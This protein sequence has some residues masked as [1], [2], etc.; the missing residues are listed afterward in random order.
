MAI[1]DFP[2]GFESWQKTHFEVVEALCYLRDLEEDKQP[3]KF[4]EFLDRTATDE[5][6]NLALKLTNKYE[7]QT[8]DK[9]RERNLFDEIEEFVAHEVK[10]L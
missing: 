6:Y 9:K 10:S 4:A 8:K 1:P 5:M 3:K 7:E 2:N